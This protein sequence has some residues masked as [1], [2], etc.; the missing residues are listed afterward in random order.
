MSD[1]ATN[2]PGATRPSLTPERY[3]AIFSSMAEG[4]VIQNIAGQIEVCNAIAERI[5]G[6]T[7]DQI[8][9]RTSVDPRW[10]AVH[11]DGSPFPGE[12]HPA[13]VTLRTGTPL[14][15]VIMG[16]HKPG[17]ELTWLSIN[18]ALVEQPGAPRS[19]ATTFSDITERRNA[20]VAL[21]QANAAVA[22]AEQH[23]RLLFNSVGDA[24]VLFRLDA[25]GLPGSILEANDNASRLLGYTRDELKAMPLLAIVPP[26]EHPTDPD[27]VRH[28]LSQHGV[29]REANLLA[30]D[31]RRIPVEIVTHLVAMDGQPTLISSLRDISPRKDAER[32]IQALSEGAI[33]GIFHTGLDG[34]MI[35]A[36][37]A[38]ARMLGYRSAQE[39]VSTITD[40]GAQVWLSPAERRQAIHSASD[41]G[42]LRGWECQFR[43]RDG[44]LTWVSVSCRE[45][46][47]ERGEP[48][49]EGFIEDISLRKHAEEERL[50]LESRLAQSQKL[51]AVGQ[52][53]AGIS[54]EFN[55]ILMIISAYC[56]LLLTHDDLADFARKYATI[57]KD[58][59]GRAANLTH[60]LLAFARKQTFYPA[61]LDLDTEIRNFVP[62][63]QPLIGEEIA[64]HIQTDPALAKV[65]ADPDQLQQLL[66]NLALNSRDAMPGGGDLQI[67]ASNITLGPDAAAALDPE[68]VPGPYVLLRVTD[69][70]C[71][72]EE[73]IRL[74]AFEPFFTTKDVGEGTGLGLASV[75]GIV[76][77]SNGWAEIHSEPNL[78]TIV[79]IYLPAAPS[80]PSFPS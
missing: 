4:V 2:A 28:R 73:A 1:L 25:T 6:L 61:V 36:N 49:Y 46:M 74:R 20:E 12:D 22:R 60:Q 80:T 24:I 72:M 3:S 5:L 41:D 40:M 63:L 10:R 57:M 55:N 14:S 58:A 17:G 50:L 38:L 31:G 44:T 59:S 26:D 62:L 42:V 32:K 79:R 30:R 16:V 11:E 70:G 56:D 78:G 8:A 23:Y 75:Y 15:N 39:L 9:G 19:V 37:P 21:Q 13:M 45:V 53:A 27:L 66:L 29:L 54:H 52:L 64:I 7:A 69:T 34:R 43:R 51:Q 47:N 48:E 68:A 71:G 76:R 33:E 18:S 77:Q 35:S 67:S 65:A